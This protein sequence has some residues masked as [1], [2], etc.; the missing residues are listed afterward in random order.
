VRCHRTNQQHCSL[1]AAIT[2]IVLFFN[3]MHQVSMISF[4]PQ[5]CRTSCDSDV[6]VWFDL[7]LGELQRVALV[8]SACTRW[9]FSKACCSNRAA[10]RSQSGGRGVSICM[11]TTHWAVCGS[12]SNCPCPRCWTPLQCEQQADLLHKTDAGL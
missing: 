11:T 7:H 5:T 8:F 1:H 2:V 10:D 3:Y 4:C 6:L 12:T 9:Q